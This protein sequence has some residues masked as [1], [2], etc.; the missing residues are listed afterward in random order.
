MTDSNRLRLTM[1]EETTFSTTPT[2]PAMIPIPCTGQSLAD[3]IGYAQSR[4]I[5]NTRDV[6]DL[7]RLDR[8]SV[9]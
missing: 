5:R 6:Q 4:I 7:V 3:Q 8:K 2:N 9:V 1:V